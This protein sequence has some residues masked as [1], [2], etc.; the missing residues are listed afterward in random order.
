MERYWIGMKNMFRYLLD[1]RDLCIRKEDMTMV[2][3][4][5]VGHVSN[6]H[7]PTSYTGFVFSNGGTTFSWKSTRLTL[8]VASTNHSENS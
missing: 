4:S 6:P 5:N 8:V 7:N 2:I 1:T 3:Y